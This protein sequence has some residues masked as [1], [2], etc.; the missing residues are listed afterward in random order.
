MIAVKP[1]TIDYSNLTASNV[2][3]DDYPLYYELTPY[4]TG[5]RV[6]H[7]DKNYEAVTD[8]TG[9]EPG[10][11]ATKWLDLGSTNRFA[12][13]D[14]IVGTQTVNAN[15]IEFSFVSSGI[16][17]A[18]GLLEVQAESIEITV[19]DQYGDGIV[20]Q[21]TLQMAD[22]GVLDWYGYFFDDYYIKQSQ[23][24]L[25]LPPY[26]GAT[27]SVSINATAEV[28]CGMF[29]AGRQQ[30]IGGTQY[31]IS[32]GITDYSRK[33]TDEFGNTSVIERGYANRANAKLSIDT[34]QVARIQSLLSSWRAIP[35][36]YIGGSE[37]ES[38]H[39]FGFYKD[40]SVVIGNPVFSDCNIEIEGLI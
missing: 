36:L 1:I 31:G 38:T 19:T 10:T 33:Q 14:G 22:T 8:V 7:Q 3:E 37:L 9:I 39:V 18:I 29:I 25:N 30:F 27:I 28:K 13:F 23:V 34:P 32:T 16:V 5:E 17:D 20:Y 12:M 21:S 15:S 11:D 4:V 24:L 2:V 40:F 26:A 6:L 35:M